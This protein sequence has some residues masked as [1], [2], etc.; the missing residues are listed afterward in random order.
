MEKGN[1][2]RHYNMS[3]TNKS[4]FTVLER[5]YN[6]GKR[7]EFI[8][9]EI[10]MEIVKSRIDSGYNPIEG[11][12]KNGGNPTFEKDFSYGSYDVRFID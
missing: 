7:F 6:N 12:S 1:L 2:P 9:P 5:A 4:I 3:G 8:D 10:T 11:A